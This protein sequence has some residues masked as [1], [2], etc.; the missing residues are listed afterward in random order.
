M[1]KEIVVYPYNRIPLNNKE[2]TTDETLQDESQKPYAKWKKSDTR[3]HKF[4]S[5]PK[6]L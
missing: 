6:K 5:I 2:G 4:E 3:P 1:D